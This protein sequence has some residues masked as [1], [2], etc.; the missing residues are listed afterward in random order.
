[1][2]VVQILDHGVHADVPFIAMELLEGETLA[3]RLDAVR[4]LAP[5]A[6]CR[7][8]GHVA[9][10]VTKAHAL[11]IVHRDLKPQNV[12]LVRDDDEDEIAKVFDFGIAKLTAPR[13][14]GS[15][16][17]TSVGSLLGTPEYMSPEQSRGEPVDFR[18]DLYALGVVAFECV[19]G[20]LPFRTQDPGEVLFLAARGEL[21]RPSEVA[22]VPP[23]FDAWFARAVSKDPA[24]RFDSAKT[25]IAMLREVLGQPAT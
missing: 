20:Y 7:V 21:L 22:E 12:F 17:S 18:T 24:A 5:A 8:L 6:V 9:K 23:G 15:M 14:E 19:T 25:Q 3:A 10:A 16:S 1:L 11:G 13:L 4:R 2:H